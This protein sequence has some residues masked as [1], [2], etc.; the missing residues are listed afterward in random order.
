M[1]GNFQQGQS[2]EAQLQLSPGKCYTIVGAGLPPVSEVNLEIQA[3]TAIPGMPPLLA[4]DSDTG[5]QA[6]L[7][8]KPNCYAWPLPMSA[9]VKVVLSVANGSGLAAAQVY[10]K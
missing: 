10:E 3:A 8:H 2:L 1:V 9:P 5:T 6:V 7:G 4:Q